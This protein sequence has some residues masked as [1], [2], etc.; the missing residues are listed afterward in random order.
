MSDT[1][2]PYQAPESEAAPISGSSGL[3]D[4]AAA[5]LGATHP[6]IRF[7]AVLSFVGAGFLVLAGIGVLIFGLGFGSVLDFNGGA[8]ASLTGIV[9]IVMAILL[10]FPAR[11]LWLH[12]NAM[13][14]FAASGNEEDLMLSLS[15]GKSFWKFCGIISIVNIGIVAVSIFFLV[16]SGFMSSF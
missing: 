6:W 5:L 2:N 7:L 8:T 4:Q 12:G 14:D 10:F 16:I 15:N 11:Y 3:P 1:Q 9:Y 13:R